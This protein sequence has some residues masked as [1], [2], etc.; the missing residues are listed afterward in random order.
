[1]PN[2]FDKILKE[3]IKPIERTLLK[4]LLG[5][6]AAQLV[7]YDAKMQITFER[8][9]DHIR[10]VKHKNKKLDY[11]LQIEFHTSN[12]DLRKRNLV[13]YSFFY[14]N[15]G[16]RLEQVVIY[17]GREK[18]TLI[19][20]DWLR[21]KN[22]SHKFK[23]IVLE[24]VP[25]DEFLVSDIPEEVVI[26]ILCN[27][28]NDSKEEVVRKIL[29]R[30]NQL[31]KGKNQHLKFQK[32][33]LTLAR[34]R[35]LELIVKNQT[36]AM[37]IHYDYEKDGLYLEGIERGIERGIEKGIEKGIE[38]GREEGIEEGIELEKR[39][40]VHSLWSLQEFSFEK[41][42]LLVGLDAAQFQKI[43]IELL[44][45]EEKTEEEAWEIIEQY[46]LRFS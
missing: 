4:K 3:N 42:A 32:Q 14:N 24:E 39:N 1:M 16:L 23:V 28:G 30:L 21:H 43:V 37:T 36:E 17:I 34:L 46:K 9:M 8:E 35:N 33:L 19:K 20:K 41:M 15:T 27:F 12:E 38:L 31:L 29:N 2:T 26:A 18:P 40:F 10:I 44:Q 11:G 13:H 22:L 5:I 7:P 6:D 45:A 25:K